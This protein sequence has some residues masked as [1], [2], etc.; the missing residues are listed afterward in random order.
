MIS[1]SLLLLLLLAMTTLRASEIA[2]VRTTSASDVTPLWC[3]WFNTYPAPVTVV[4]VLL[5]YNNTQDYEIIA[6]GAEDNNVTPSQFNGYKPAYFKPGLNL[7]SLHMPDT[8]NV[9]R[10]GQSITWSL[11]GRSV[12]VD[13]SMLTTEERCD[14]KY[15]GACPTWIDGFC[16]DT[17]FCNG[18]ETC[19]SAVAHYR[20]L[21][22]RVM[23]NCK[24]PPEGVR[25]RN[26][27][28]CNDT[29]RACVSSAPPPPPPP[30]I[31]P[32]LTCWFYSTLPPQPSSGASGFSGSGGDTH[33]HIAAP[34]YINLVLGYN[35]TGAA[36]AVRGITLSATSAGMLTNNVQPDVYNTYQSTVFSVGVTREAFTLFDTMNVMR[37]GGTI[38][39]TLTDRQLVIK[40]TDLTD[41]LLCGDSPTATPSAPTS[42]N[43][44]DEVT[45][46][47]PTTTDNN[48]SVSVGDDDV[49]VDAEP[50]TLGPSI[51]QCS[52]NNTDCTAYD[53][54]C[55]GRTVCDTESELCVPVDPSYTPCGSSLRV[56]ELRPRP[57]MPITLQ[58]VEHAAVCVA[59]TDSC[60]SNRDCND[61]LLCTGQETC[62]NSTCVTEPNQTVA[63]ICGTPYAVC[64]ETVGCRPTNQL[65]GRI[66]FAITF[67]AIAALSLFCLLIYLYFG[68][69]DGATLDTT[70]S[71]SGGT[72]I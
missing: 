14:V 10:G 61:G 48:A 28:V 55:N 68:Y 5:G 41:E 29:A 12:V 38:T 21:L 37:N 15:R 52:V 22:G 35:N 8:R 70:M 18:K 42:V 20:Q 32:L 58:C 66:I 57:G 63:Q 56:S 62:V 13:S 26:S 64:I 24:P 9:L 2:A 44:D 4:N 40:N 23:G 49:P 30:T 33:H 54:F 45:S 47:A 25:C 60:Y 51:Q 11:G 34:M 27:E 65:D 46:G 71:Q 16:D 19:F 72:V 69:G 39:W 50:T 43:R 1:V 7:Y 3:C 59:V 53:S 36:P 17:Q 6:T 31:V 67:G